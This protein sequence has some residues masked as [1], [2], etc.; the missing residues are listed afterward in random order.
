M[1][2]FGMRIAALE[3]KIGEI[4]RH[5]IIDMDAETVND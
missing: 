1:N 5:V 3:K 2:R 4:E